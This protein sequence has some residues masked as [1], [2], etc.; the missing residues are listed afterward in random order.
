MDIRNSTTAPAVIQRNDT[1]MPCII[2]LSPYTSAEAVLT[3]VMIPTN[4]AEPIEPAIVRS[5][6]RSDEAYATIFL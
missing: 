3:T 5:E 4:T 6:V 1:F 2:A